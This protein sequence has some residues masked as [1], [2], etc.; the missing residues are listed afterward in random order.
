MTSQRNLLSLLTILIAALSLSTGAEI[1]QPSDGVSVRGHTVHGADEETMLDIERALA[2]FDGAGLKLPD[3][4]IYVYPT[5]DGCGGLGG[6][7]ERQGSKDRVSVCSRTRRAFA[8]LHEFA[9]AWEAHAVSDT[10][11]QQFLEM[12]GLAKWRSSE[13]AWAERGMEQ[14]AETIATGLLDRPYPNLHV[15]AIDELEASYQ[16]LTGAPSPRLVTRDLAA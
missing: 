8:I 15:P 13:V 11:R 5:P 10:T 9:H 14:A 7:Y 12:K 2:A 6:L 4:G 3:L 1:I 16:L